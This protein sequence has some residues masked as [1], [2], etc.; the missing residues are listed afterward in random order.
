MQ[1]ES[2]FSEFF[3]NAKI[4]TR[5]TY[6]RKAFLLRELILEGYRAKEG[7]LKFSIAYEFVEHNEKGLLYFGYNEVCKILRDHQLISKYLVQDEIFTVW[8]IK[9]NIEI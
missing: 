3:D 2:Y 7:F 6:N 1:D 4:E 9:A 5:Y 8:Y